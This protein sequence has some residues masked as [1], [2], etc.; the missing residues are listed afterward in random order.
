MGMFSSSKAPDAR[1]AVKN[2]EI[3][4]RSE[5]PWRAARC[6]GPL[7][8][9]SGRDHFRSS[10]ALNFQLKPWRAHPAPAASAPS[11]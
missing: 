8:E 11:R 6:V 5:S 1:P 9:Q 3:G 2:I 10:Y 4:E 7:P